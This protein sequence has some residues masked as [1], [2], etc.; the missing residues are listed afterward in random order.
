MENTVE[1]II[2]DTNPL[3]REKKRNEAERKGRNAWL[4]L[5]MVTKFERKNL[6][7]FRNCLYW[8]SAYR[9]YI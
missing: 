4:L 9:F 8:M 1:K 5:S 3:R 7:K 2:K 6:P